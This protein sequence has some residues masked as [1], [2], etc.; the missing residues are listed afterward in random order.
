MLS[1]TFENFFEKAEA[2][3]ASGIP[4]KSYGSGTKGIVCGDRL[5][6]EVSKASSESSQTSGSQ[7]GYDSQQSNQQ[8]E[9]ETEIPVET[10][11][12]KNIPSTSLD[13]IGDA[14]TVSDSGLA[15]RIARAN[16]PV[17][18]PLNQGYFEGDYVYFIVTDSSE[19][20]MSHLISQRQGQK[21][22]YSPLLQN[23]SEVS[24]KVYVF[25]NGVNGNGIFG[26]QNE[27]FADTPAQ[28]DTYSP[29]R[30]HYHI[31]WNNPNTAWTL[32]TEKQILKAERDDMISIRPVPI[33]TNMPQIVWPEG[34]IPVKEDKSISNDMLFVGGQVTE[35]NLDE[36]YVTF[37][38]HRSWGPDG[39]TVYYIVTDATPSGPADALGV[40]HTPNSAKLI[41]SPAAMDFFHFMDGISGSGPWGFQP[42]IMASAPW[43]GTYSPI[44]RIHVISWLDSYQVALLQTIED[45]DAYQNAGI[46]EVK[47]AMPMGEDHIVNCPVVDPFN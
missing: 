28:P 9:S 39:T 21:V 27:V 44:C 26:F 11:L 20:N 3:K 40:P 33:V 45:I 2:K 10:Y 13:F 5:C 47:L 18:I 12:P 16:V 14:T 36:L 17:S 19:L 4:A 29:L 30:S 1:L 24:S 43:E 46:I 42:G 8:T 37:I 34:Q 35:I 25:E 15:I 32:T 22:L 6:S 38:A 23:A 7:S 41:S 31:T